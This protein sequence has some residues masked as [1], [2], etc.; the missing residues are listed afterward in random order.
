MVKNREIEIIM[1]YIWI[2]KERKNLLKKI[3]LEIKKS[4]LYIFYPLSQ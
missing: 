1:I 2:E 4:D 3:K